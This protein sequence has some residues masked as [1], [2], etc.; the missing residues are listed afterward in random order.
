MYATF[1]RF[2]IVMTKK[3]A[4]SVSHSGQC[5]DDVKALMENK[6]FMSQF[7]NIDKDAIREELKE[8]G[9]WDNDELT[10]DEKNLERIIWIAGGNISDELARY[11][12]G[13]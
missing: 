8:C 5:Y 1:N 7:K 10:D 6:K 3:Q 4:N 12:H 13:E 2:E 9:T 11:K